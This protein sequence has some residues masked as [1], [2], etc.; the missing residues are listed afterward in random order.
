MTKDLYH[1]T[2]IDPAQKSGHEL[3]SLKGPSTPAPGQADKYAGELATAEEQA[4]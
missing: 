4:S 2:H 1:S 3:S